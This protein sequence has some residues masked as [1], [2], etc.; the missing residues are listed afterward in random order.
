MFSC[1]RSAR[2]YPPAYNSYKSFTP[3]RFPSTHPVN[4]LPAPNQG[5]EGGGPGLESGRPPEPRFI[6]TDGQFVASNVSSVGLWTVGGKGITW[7]KQGGDLE[8][9]HW[10]E[11]GS[12]PGRFNEALSFY[13]SRRQ[14]RKPS[15]RCREDVFG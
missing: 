13:L 5:H 3:V 11:L 9:L 1:G 8:M 2:P 12:N 4:P 7:R 10:P 6:H 15:F 14:T